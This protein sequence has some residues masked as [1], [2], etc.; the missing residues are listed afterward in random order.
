MDWPPAKVYAEVYKTCVL[1]GPSL[2]RATAGIVHFIGRQQIDQNPWTGELEAV[3]QSLA[4]KREWLAGSYLESARAAVSFCFGYK[5]EE[6]DDWD[7]DQFFEKV[8]QAEYILGRPLQPADP[9][10]KPAP[11]PLTPRERLIERARGNTPPHLNPPS[12]GPDIESF[13][14]TR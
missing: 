11:K 7:P 2:P 8:V 6:I 13:T 5:F 12:E 14:F 1:S 4:M 10:A 3:Q 9:K